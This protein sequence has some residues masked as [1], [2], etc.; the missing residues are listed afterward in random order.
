MKAW[1]T[2]F[3]ATDDWSQLTSGVARLQGLGANQGILGTEA[4]QRGPGAEPR[5]GSGGK[6]VGWSNGTGFLASGAGRI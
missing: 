2:T 4:P 5:W 6:A 1:T 3:V